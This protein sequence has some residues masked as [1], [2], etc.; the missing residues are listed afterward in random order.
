V[1]GLSSRRPYQVVVDPG[2]Q[3]VEAWSTRR[4]TFEPKGWLRSLR[5]ELRGAL[6][7][8]IGGSDRVLAAMYGSPDRELCD[9]ENVL[10]YNIGAGAFRVVAANGLRLERSYVCPEPPVA[11]DGA[12]R[13]YVRYAAGTRVGGFEVWTEGNVLA[14]WSRI[15]MPELTE[16]TKPATVWYAVAAASVDAA[17][18]I[19]NQ[20]PFGVRLV[21]E[22]PR[23]HRIAPAKI[24]KPLL[25]GTIAALHCHDGSALTEVSRRVS[26]QIS[27]APETIAAMLVDDRSAVLGARRL[28]W[29]RAQGVQWNPA[30]DRCFALE[31][32]ICHGD[33]LALTGRLTAI[34]PSGV[35]VAS[36]P[37]S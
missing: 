5:E 32:R 29:P 2:G 25:D 16:M 19:E 30:D 1:S 18:N 35:R 33:R 7:T 14:A 37:V 17:T 26:A 23:N 27:V 36:G 21:L 13:H 31:I 9:V 20:Q 34:T 3:C 8:L 15:P 12:A 6:P 24:I 4:L 28:L 22:A 10:L 11:L